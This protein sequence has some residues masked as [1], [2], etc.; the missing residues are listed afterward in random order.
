MQGVVVCDTICCNERIIYE[1]KLI[2]NAYN[3]G[4]ATLLWMR[5]E[6]GNLECGLPVMH[7]VSLTAGTRVLFY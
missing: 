2:I 1:Y 3:I 4:I 5:Y 6:V 7:A